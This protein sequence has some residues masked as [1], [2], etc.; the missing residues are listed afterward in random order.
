MKCAKNLTLLSDFHDGLLSGAEAA[1]VRTHLMLCLSCRE[2]FHDLEL[3]VS[4]AAELRDEDHVTCHN[5]KVSWQQI[6][7]TAL[8]LPESAR[9]Q[10]RL[11]LR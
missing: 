11:P 8:S 9:G 2:I 5:E 1:S 4:A 3:I 7:A 10:Q 6:R